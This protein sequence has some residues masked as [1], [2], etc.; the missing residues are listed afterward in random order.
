[1]YKRLFVICNVYV[2]WNKRKKIKLEKN[3]LKM[4]LCNYL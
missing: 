2:L 4:D 1:M 3:Y